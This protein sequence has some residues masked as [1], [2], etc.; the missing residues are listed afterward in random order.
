MTAMAVPTDGPEI[1][2]GRVWIGKI[3]LVLALAWFG[4]V[5]YIMRPD[6]PHLARRPT[7]VITL[8]DGT[9]HRVYLPSEVFGSNAGW[10]EDVDVK[11]EY[12]AWDF[13]QRPMI[14]FLIIAIGPIFTALVG[15][16]LWLA[17]AEWRVRR[18]YPSTYESLF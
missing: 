2:T 10:M 13:M 1:G 11:H 12:T 16:F 15:S 18:R 14:K 8:A 4:S 9:T 5:F 3:F 17:V 6:Q 7:P